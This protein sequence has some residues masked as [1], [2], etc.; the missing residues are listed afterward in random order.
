MTAARKRQPS[1]AAAIAAIV[2]AGLL[3][4][5]EQRADGSWVL[6]GLPRDS[7]AT[8]DDEAADLG[9][10]MQQLGGVGGGKVR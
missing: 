4:K 6:T 3:P 9:A 10:R 8:G 7:V 2:K 5:L 1:Q